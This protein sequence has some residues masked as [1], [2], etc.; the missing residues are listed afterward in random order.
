MII[1]VLEIFFISV[2]NNPKNTVSKIFTYEFLY[3]AYDDDTTFFLKSRISIKE[4]MNE[5]NIKYL[6]LMLDFSGLKPNKKKCKIA[7]IGVL[8][9]VQMTLCD[10]KCVN[11]NNETVKILGVHLFYFE[12]DKNFCEHIVKIEKDLKL[13]RMTQLTLRGRIMVFK[14]LV[15]SEVIIFY[16]LLNYIIIQLIFCRKYRKI[17]F[18]KGKR[19]KLNTVLFAMTMKREIYKMST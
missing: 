18:G 17:L 3:T 15:A 19:Q 1:L 4:L 6:I 11:L 16:L 10:M 9:R 5:L 12:Q 14:S 8:N 2:K 7:V 13:W